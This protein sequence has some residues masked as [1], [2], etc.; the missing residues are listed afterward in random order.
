MRPGKVPR[1]ALM[2]QVTATAPD[3]GLGPAA[4][5]KAFLELGQAVL[6]L[7]G[8]P[9]CGTSCDYLDGDRFLLAASAPAEDKLSASCKCR[10]AYDSASA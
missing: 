3:D 10:S 7:L 4:F 9:G 1:G 2:D 5:S 8:I 6:I